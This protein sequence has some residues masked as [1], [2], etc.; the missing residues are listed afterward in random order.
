MTL[1]FDRREE[2]AGRPGLHAL[3]VGVSNYRN[4]PVYKHLLEPHHL[5][6]LRLNAA[7]RT[8]YR[9]AQWLVERGD[10]L[11]VPLASC[12]LLLSSTTAERK[13]EPGLA[14]VKNRATLKNFKSTA[15]GWRLDANAREDNVAFF[16]FSGHGI[17]RRRQ[18]HVI[19]LEDFGKPCPM[20]LGYGIATNE[21]L[22]GMGPALTRPQVAQRQIYFIDAC[23]ISPAGLDDVEDPKVAGLWDEGTLRVDPRAL[24]YIF[25][26]GEGLPAFEVPQEY[27]IFG[28]ALLDCMKGGAAV[29]HPDKRSWCVTLGSLRD[30]LRR[31]M[32]ELNRRHKIRQDF[33]PV[34]LAE[35]LILH[36]QS[37]SPVVRVDIAVDPPEGG[38]YTEVSVKRASSELIWRLRPPVPAVASDILPVGLYV[39]EARIDPPTHPYSN[40]NDILEARMPRTEWP[41]PLIR[42]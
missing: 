36:S 39:V 37:D 24:S 25:A 5:G 33:R 30:S 21:L 12:R 35:G 40:Y 4:L 9:L 18:D 28:S 27:T 20:L 1:F 32:D 8:A 15:E 17:Q 41:I 14:N 10:H 22:N 31:Y 13:R 19:L 16:Y 29:Y 2:F 6:M 3:I 11:T 34:E 26:T 42:P 23:R 7:A 38:A